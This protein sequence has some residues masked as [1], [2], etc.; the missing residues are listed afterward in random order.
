M[1]AYK[2]AEISANK[3]ISKFDI[4]ETP[5]PV[6]NIAEGL[7]IQIRYAHSDDY[8]GILV[9]KGKDKALM[10]VNSYESPKRVRFTI[11]HE[12]GHFVL[13][14]K[15]VSIDYRNSN[16]KRDKKEAV[17]DEFAANLLMPK[18]FIK[19]DFEK[20]ISKK[21]FLDEHLHSLAE[22][23]QVSKEAM[24][25]RLERLSLISF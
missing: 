16:K 9:R 5:V 20:I 14:K 18:K 25:I 13:E 1:D 19:K 3:I 15:S 7:G 10:G 22:Q 11:A 6:E 23:Y 17:M 2:K 12:I 24:K 8:S 21:I 4:Q